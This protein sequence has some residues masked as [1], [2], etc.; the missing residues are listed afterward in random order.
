MVVVRSTGY[1]SLTFQN[2][3]YIYIYIT[4]TTFMHIYVYVYIL[5]CVCIS[6]LYI[7]LSK[8]QRIWIFEA[9]SNKFSVI[10][11]LSLLL[12]LCWP[13]FHLPHCCSFPF[14]L[15]YTSY[16]LNYMSLISSPHLAHDLITLPWFL[17]I[18]PAVYSLLKIGARYHW[19]VR[20][21][22]ACVSGTGLIH[23]VESF[24][25]SYLIRLPWVVSLK[26]MNDTATFY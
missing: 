12:L 22:R 11:L 8:Y 19:W 10:C 17:C 23:S 6:V 16:H 2:I 9:L 21:C 20:G 26:I 24:V 3:H 15:F 13:P 4:Y 5:M 14:I 7:I 18:L 1:L 25:I